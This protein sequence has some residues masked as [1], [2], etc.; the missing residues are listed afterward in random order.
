MSAIHPSQLNFLARHAPFDHM[1]PGHLLWMLERMRLGYYAAGEVI[2]SPE[3]GAVDRFLVIKQGMVHGEQNVA[4]A[5]E[6]DTWLEL[7]EGECF[8]LGALLADRP[9]A[10]VY[11]A[12]SDTFCYEL[13]AADFRQLN[14]MSA[15]FRDFCTR[16]IANLLEHSKQV[17]QAQY[18]HSSVEQQSL[19]SPLSAI[20]RRAPVTCAPDTSV[21]RVLE[22]M[23]EQRIGSMVATDEE[24]RPLGIL[25]LHD[26]LDRIALPQIDLD[27]PVIQ[28]MSAHLSSMPPQA[29]AHEAALMMAKHGFRHVLVVE[30]ERLI[31]LIS[32]KDLFALQRVGLREIGSTIRHAE[33]PEVLQQ[34]AADIRHM[35]HNM[36]AQGVAPE[37]LTQFISTFNDLL[38]ARVV[39]L[40]CKASGLLGTPLHEGLCWMA[41]GSEGRVEQTLNTDQ[42]NAIIFDVPQGMDADEVREKLLPVAK[43]I[44]ETLALCGFP[45]CKGEIMAGNPKWCLSLEEWKRTFSGWL[46]GGSPEALLHATIFFD[47]RS[48]YGAHHLAEDLRGWLARVASDNSRFLHLM[49]E[50]ALNNRPPLGVVR[51]FVVGK[52]NKL[53]LKV[54]GITPFVDAARIFS[55]AAGVTQTNTIQ[56][57][58]LS[59]AKMNLHESEIDAWID[60]LLF[61]QVLRLR[62]HDESSAEGAGD[63]AL[64]NKIDPE[65][66]NE[67]DR[68][69]L[70]EAFRQARKLQA[71]LSLEYHL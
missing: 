14:E 29:Q 69:I 26:V 21:R 43:R 57:L 3:Q 70:K 25:T 13:P 18:S 51:D 39:E 30:N 60:A 44:N 31:G 19:A 8:P 6:A 32:E 45:L 49:A 16:R 5:S 56:R 36:M 54:N 17:I 53:D 40:E 66:L 12:G 38:T 20:I 61:I 15:A 59:A 9:V 62:H 10:S 1:E 46:S 34:A 68:R 42:D 58:R 23:H 67:L 33:T 2:V 71:R 65:K 28:V 47:F 7:A 41:L 48:L 4:H 52:E 50:N 24:A 27:Q 11:R 63:A 55:L 35:A 64:D 22:V 37:Q